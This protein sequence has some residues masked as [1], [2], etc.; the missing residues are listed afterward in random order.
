MSIWFGSLQLALW[1]IPGTVKALSS[2]GSFTDAV[3]RTSAFKVAL[4]WPLY[5][6]VELSWQ[7]GERNGTWNEK[8][9]YK[10]FYS[11]LC[12]QNFAINFANLAIN[13]ANLEDNVFKQV[14]IGDKTQQWGSTAKKMLRLVQSIDTQTWR[15][16]R[17][18]IKRSKRNQLNQHQTKLASAAWTTSNKP[19]VSTTSYID[20]TDCDHRKENWSRSWK[21]WSPCGWR[22][23]KTNG[24]KVEH[25]RENEVEK[26]KIKKI[27]EDARKKLCFSLIF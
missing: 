26:C 16:P 15:R 21:K 25:Q 14:V 9:K 3:P 2:I 17:N 20:C 5:W 8:K 23:R 27:V 7:D 6:F 10:C 13:F 22:R 1:S 24:M 19:K 11:I 4:S 12:Y 18:N